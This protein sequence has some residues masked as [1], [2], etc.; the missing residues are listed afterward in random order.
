MTAPPT[1]EE[2]ENECGL[3]TLDGESGATSSVDVNQNLRDDSDWG[4][5]YRIY[6]GKDGSQ[7]VILL[8]G[9]SKNRQDEDIQAAKV[10]W[11]EY[12]RRKSQE[13][14]QAEAKKKAGSN[15]DEWFGEDAL[16]ESRKISMAV[17]NS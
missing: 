16:T 12:K 11:R 3:T 8:G 13:L 2:S 15:L 7:L 4:P 10:A 9:G 17:I 14:K 5:G 6:L 1:G